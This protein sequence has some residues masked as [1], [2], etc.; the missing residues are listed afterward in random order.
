MK[1]VQKMI[2]F[3]LGLIVLLFFIRLFLPSQV[4]DVTPGI[5]CEEEILDKADVYYV[6]PNFEGESISENLEWCSMI[7]DS[8]KELAL[9]GYEHTYQEFESGDASLKLDNGIEI[10]EECFGYSPERFKAPNLAINSENK[11]LVKSQM[12]LDGI[13]NQ[14]FHK[15]YHCSDSGVFSNR[16]VSL[17]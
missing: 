6:V 5:Y 8:E 14:V 3:I 17:F 15:V 2:I 1:L 16:F 4:D 7:L 12:E 10:F 9:H 13:F 11:K